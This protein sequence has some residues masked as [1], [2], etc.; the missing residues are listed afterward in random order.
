MAARQRDQFSV[1][2]GISVRFAAFLIIISW[3]AIATAQPFAS[4]PQACN[5]AANPAHGAW[6]SLTLPDSTKLEW[7]IGMNGEDLRFI[8]LRYPGGDQGRFLTGTRIVRCGKAFPQDALYILVMFKSSIVSEAS[9]LLR[10][11]GFTERLGAQIDRFAESL[12]TALKIPA[13]RP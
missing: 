4:D 10:M 11:P 12:Q 9:H 5:L 6:K 8:D 1:L 7:R 3:A 2:F 13:P